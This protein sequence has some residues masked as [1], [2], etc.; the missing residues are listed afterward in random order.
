MKADSGMKTAG[1]T[2]S[3]AVG[4]F[5]VCELI[6]FRMEITCISETKWFGKDVQEIDGY[7]VLRG[8][9]ITLWCR[10]C[11]CMVSTHTDS[12]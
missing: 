3:I 9:C 11:C 12:G 6:R 7:T 10:E 2:Y 8:W 1:G 5:L 4:P